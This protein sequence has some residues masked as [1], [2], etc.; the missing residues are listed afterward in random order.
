MSRKFGDDLRLGRLVR[1]YK[2]SRAQV[3][4]LL[5]LTL[6]FGF[7]A[8]FI[9]SGVFS[10]EMANDWA[11]KIVLSV[12]GALLSLPALAGWYVLWRGRGSSVRLYERGLI[13]R[14]SGRE[15]V[16]AW[17]EIASYTEHAA[18]RIE[19]KDG[20][21]FD[22]GANVE[23]YADVADV[24]KEETLRLM[25]PAARAALRKGASLEFKGLQAEENSSAGK[26]LNRTILS[27]AGFTLDA[28]GITA[29]AE[30][31]RIAWA[32]VVDC[33][34]M[35]APYGKGKALFFSI[36]DPHVSL[37]MR[38][39]TLPNAHLLLALCEETVRS[40]QPGATAPAK[41]RSITK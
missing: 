17:D 27:A 26:L 32:D 5:L 30:G 31:Q 34:V 40:K 28:D 41:E 25:L 36:S 21:A 39:G 1:E 18:C 11:G 20:E 29:V 38:Y 35:E 8:A 22:F 16:T 23:G 6:V 37:Q 10:R 12:L 2:R 3:V 9:F 15:F 7:G 33:G 4:K 24:I 19:K 14:R 13:Y